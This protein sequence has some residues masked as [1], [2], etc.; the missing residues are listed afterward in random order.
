MSI[1]QSGGMTILHVW[2]CVWVG[3]AREHTRT[4]DRVLG[5]PKS[6]SSVRQTVVAVCGYCILFAWI[7]VKTPRPALP[8]CLP[9]CHHG[10][11]AISGQLHAAVR[12]LA[13]APQGN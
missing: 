10:H 2:V 7:L 6:L 11:P 3:G 8:A 4:Y 13:K 12:A 9:A 5:K 1:V